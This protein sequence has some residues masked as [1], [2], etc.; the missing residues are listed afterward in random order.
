MYWENK[1]DLNNNLVSHAM[2]RNT[3]EKIHQYLH[4]HDNSKLNPCDKVYKVRPLLDH[5]NDKF[6]QFVEPM[7][8]YFSLDKAMKSYYRHHG[9]KQ[10]IRGKP[11]CYGFEFWCLDRPDGFLI[12]SKTLGSSVSKILSLKFIPVGSS[13]YI[14]NYFTSLPLMDAL[15]NNGLFCVGTIRNNR[16][17]KAPLQDVSKVVRGICCVAEDKKIGIT[18]PKW[19]DNNQVNLV[20]NLKAEVFDVGSCKQ[21]KKSER[22][23][24]SVL[25]SNIVK[26]YNKQ[27]GGVDLFDKLRGHY[28]IRIRSRKWYRPLFRFY[29][30]ENI[31]NLWIL[32]CY[33]QRNISLRQIVTA[34]LAA[35]NL[36]KKRVVHPKTKKQVPQVAQFDNRDHLVNK[37]ETQ[38]QCAVCGKC[39]K[40]VCIKCNVSLFPDTCFLPFHQ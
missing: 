26:L 24:V 17:E 22:N 32:C 28:Q 12:A 11:I 6:Y 2:S 37:I 14:D 5:L 20:A 23:R 29:L 39:T 25:Q 27:M 21:W 3:F 36:E 7:G 40:F 16:T 4:F 10:F 33:I 30:N 1:S 8:S 18:L 34:L 31:V 19:L 35:P 38:R 15:S 9:M 13:I